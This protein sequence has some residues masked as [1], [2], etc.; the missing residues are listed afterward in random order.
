MGGMRIRFTPPKQHRIEHVEPRI[1]LAG[2]TILAHG[3]EGNITGWIPAA[4]EAI[5][6]KLGGRGSIFRMELENDGRDV[7]VTSFTRTAGAD[8]RT[9]ERAEYIIMLDWTDVDGALFS[10][11]PVGEAVADYL[12][13]PHDGLPALA[14]LPIHL[15]GHSRGAS[16]T[17]VIAERLGERGIWIDQHTSLDPHPID[18]EDDFL[19]L[20]FGDESMKTWSNIIFADNYWR[21]DGQTQNFDFDGEPVAGTHEG[22]LNDTV[23]EDHVGSAH[24][25]VTTYYHGTID[26]N[27]RNNNEGPILSDWYGNSS[28]KPSR[29]QTGYIFSR[30]QGSARPA[31]GLA[32]PFGGAATR[33]AVGEE[34]S[35]WGSL[36]A[37]QVTN[38]SSIAVG[39]TLKLRFLRQDRDSGVTVRFF[40]DTDQ[41]PFNNNNA[42]TVGQANYSANDAIVDTRFNGSSAGVNPGKYYVY[43]QITDDSGHASHAYS[44]QI[45]LTSPPAN[46]LFASVSNGVLIANGTSGTDNLAI[47]RGGGVFSV[48]L[49]DFTQTFSE[50]VVD[51]IQL[52]PGDGHDIVTVYSG[53][54]STYINGGG[55]NDTLIGA[56]G[57]DTFSGSGGNDSLVGNAGADVLTGNA[58]SDILLGGD[59]E[60]RIYADDGTRDTVDGASGFDRAEIDDLDIRSGINE[61]LQ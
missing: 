49:N 32:V 7:E 17:T 56:E 3:F 30:I 18:G 2:V 43:G 46:L 23:E 34:G 14:S 50:S 4:A 59:G 47:S 5:N 61:I 8:P 33:I 12:L 22:D 42:R 48:Q 31:D 40:L 20:D 9:S 13:S 1:L 36:T 35:Q 16:L 6:A 26:P 15:V 19:G 37:L 28:S 21:T 44:R 58:G 60:D 41:N 11:K 45:T 24:M 53:V 27:A 29:T 25:A 52:M 10:T 55:G 57:N 38:G 51:S 39:Q 54:G